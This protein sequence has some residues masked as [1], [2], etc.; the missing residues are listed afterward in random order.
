M[1]RSLT[2]FAFGISFAIPFGYGQTTPGTP[3][4]PQTPARTLPPPAKTNVPGPGP[5][6]NPHIFPKETRE[7][8]EA[9]EEAKRAAAPAA[10]T[11]GAE[12]PAPTTETELLNMLVA[13]NRSQQR[14]A[15][16]A[17]RRAQDPEVK[18]L[19]ETMVQDLTAG[20]KSL[21]QLNKTLGFDASDE[22]ETG[23]DATYLRLSQL[24]G[25]EFDRAYLKQVRLAQAANLSRFEAAEGFA[26]T[27]A[28]RS[29]LNT[30]QRAMRTSAQQVDRLTAASAATPASGP[31]TT[32]IAP[33]TTPQAA[34]TVPG[35]VPNVNPGA[36]PGAVPGTIPGPQPGASPNTQPAGTPGENPT[37]ATGPGSEN[38]TGGNRSRAPRTGGTTGGAPKT[39][40]GNPAGGGA[41]APSGR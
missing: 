23:S 29:Y 4:L 25:A 24:D 41:P 16:L 35:S 12:L 39:E 15:Q 11:P 22:A 37:P 17:A 6:A 7:A 2:I 36:N 10:G 1:K 9:A 18:T 20:G 38:P 32:G 34:P 13:S 30:N 28:L 3:E 8:R 31:T 21:A 19:A 14:L 40:S 27:K 5:G 26:K 33:G